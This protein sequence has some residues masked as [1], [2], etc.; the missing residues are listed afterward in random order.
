VVEEDF[1]RTLVFLGSFK[2]LGDLKTFL[3]QR[4]LFLHPE[5]FVSYPEAAFLV[6]CDPS[7]IEL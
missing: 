3:F 5:Y 7:V 6:V 4:L 1:I 2:Y